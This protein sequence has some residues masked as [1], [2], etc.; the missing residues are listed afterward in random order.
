MFSGNSVSAKKLYLLYDEK[1][2]HHNV[3]TNFKAAMAKMYICNGCD[4]LYDHTHKC[5]NFCPYVHQL[6]PVRKIRL[7]IVLHATG[8]F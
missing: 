2:K 4:T 7:G 5:D 1:N 6:H 3:I 8:G